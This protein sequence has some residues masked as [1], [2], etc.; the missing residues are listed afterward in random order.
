MCIEP[1]I[2][3]QTLMDYQYLELQCRKVDSSLCYEIYLLVI[4][5][6]EN[7][8]GSMIDLQLFENFRKCN[9]NFSRS[10]I[11]VD[12]L[13]IRKT[14]YILRTKIYFKQ[15]NLMK[16]AKYDMLFKSINS[17]MESY[18]YLTHVYC[19]KPA[20]RPNK[21]YICDTINYVKYLVD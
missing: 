20:E 9:S 6:H 12:Y 21:F 11:P 15:Y 17:A 5:K 16:S 13:S 19:E 14:L 7:I 2:Y 18:T 4:L 3:F 1:I 8:D 10:Y